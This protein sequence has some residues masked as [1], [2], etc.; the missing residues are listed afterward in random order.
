[1]CFFRKFGD[2]SCHFP[3]NTLSHCDTHDSLASL[4]RGGVIG[5]A[6]WVTGDTSK[7]EPPT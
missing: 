3:L 5:Q 2:E 1:M 6:H 4:I 7:G